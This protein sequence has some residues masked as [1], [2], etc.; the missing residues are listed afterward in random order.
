MR[1]AVTSPSMNS[2]PVWT[3]LTDP[4]VHKQLRGIPKRDADRI[5]FAITGMAANPYAGD[6]A[7]MQGE[8]DVWRRRVGS[9]RI[10]YEVSVQE[11]LVQV[12]R[13]ARRTSTT[14]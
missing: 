2:A 6:I 9:Y 11:R 10:F 13:V 5:V 1:V 12:Y 14:Y 3:V 4:Q 7:R 8:Q